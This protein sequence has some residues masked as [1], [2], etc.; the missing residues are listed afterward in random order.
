MNMEVRKR[1]EVVLITFD[2]VSDKFESNYEK[3]KFFRGLHGWKQIVPKENKSYVYHR[4]GLLD[5]VPHMKISDSVFIVALENMKRM[6]E[7][8]DEWTDKVECEMM[9]IM[10]DRDKFFKS[11]R[12]NREW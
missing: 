3:N 12:E 5:E 9:E 2:T 7:Y 4:S 10:M 6:T 11:I 8:F 1:V